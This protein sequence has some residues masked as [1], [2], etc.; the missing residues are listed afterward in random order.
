M[1]KAKG[2]SD[3]K[4]ISSCEELRT[5]INGW[6]NFG[7]S[8]NALYVLTMVVPRTWQAVVKGQCQDQSRWHRKALSLHT[9]T[10]TT[11]TCKH[12]RICIHTRMHTRAHTHTHTLSHIYILW[13][14]NDGYVLHIFP[15]LQPIQQ[16]TH[17]ENFTSYDV[18]DQYRLIHCENHSWQT[19]MR[20]KI[21]FMQGMGHVDKVHAFLSIW[22]NI[23][24]SVGKFTC[25]KLCSLSSVLTIH[26]TGGR[27]MVPTLCPLAPVMHVMMKAHEPMCTHTH[28]TQWINA[29]IF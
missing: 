8:E 10:H 9:R 6:Q 3:C 4:E 5:Q 21:M 19:G 27:E 16:W 1:G 23:I 2:Y 25:D 15:N 14:Y 24:S 13:N 12:A 18:T 17:R 11:R 29:E 20:R 28:A 26:I 7:R 22:L